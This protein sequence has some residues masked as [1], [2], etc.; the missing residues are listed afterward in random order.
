LA[1]QNPKKGDGR[2]NGNVVIGELLRNMEFGRFEMNYTVLFPCVFTVYLNPADHATLHGIFDFIS[3]DAKRAL[4]ERVMELNNGSGLFGGKRASKES[5]EH[6]IACRDWNVEFL[7]HPEVPQGDVEIH[8]E[9]NEVPEPAFR[10]IKTTLLAREPSVP[11]ETTAS[12]FRETTR[13]PSETVYGEIRYQDDSGQQV[14]LIRQNEIRIGRGGENQ[15][16]DVA[17]YTNDEVSRQHLIIRR[18][19]ATGIFTVTDLS[20][21]G[22]SIGGKRL[23]KEVEQQLPDRAEINVGEVLTL[24]FERRP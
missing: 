21:N 2:L 10:G 18:D 15:S 23:R 12:R 4:R 13:R 6:K 5:K 24:T 14:Y 1:W 19:A 17:L 16:V 20:T 8:S 11:D 22:T 7:P 9:L 3:E